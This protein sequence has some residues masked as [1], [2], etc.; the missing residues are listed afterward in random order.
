MK[1]EAKTLLTKSIDSILLAVEHFNRHLNIG[2]HEAVL[3]FLDRSFEL[4]LKSIILHKNGNIRE[5]NE[6]L[7]I[8]FNQCVRKCVSDDN[9]KC[10]SENDALTIQIINS[11]RDAAQ[12][13][14]LEMSEQQLYIYTQSA[15]T[16]YNRILEKVFNQKITDHLPER[17]LPVTSNLPMEFSSLIDVEFDDIKQMVR[18]GNRKTLDAKS[19]LLPFA[20]IESSLN[21]THTQPSEKELDEISKKIKAGKNWEEIFPAIKKLN[22]SPEGK[23]FIISLR[24]TKKEGN[25]VYIVPEGTPGATAIAIKKINDLDFYSLNLD[26]LSEKIGL[27]T[28]KTIA[29]I[30]E[31]NVQSVNDYYKEFKI[32]SVVFKRYSSLALDF[33]YKSL[34]N[35]NIDEIWGN[36][37]HFL[38]GGKK[39]KQNSI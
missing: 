20:I 12:H 22:I 25:P 23:G 4:L 19:K 15:I 5:K 14:I 24:L 8:G 31:L 37:K 39:K 1:K 38:T 3:I 11:L 13:H 21:G 7:T 10:L 35:L 9:L 29:I 18:N 16:L 36:H 34:P 27:T 32:G 26:K 2:R 30:R 28:S 6:K 17:V 33:L